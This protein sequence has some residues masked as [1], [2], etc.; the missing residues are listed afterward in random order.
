MLLMAYG[1]RAHCFRQALSPL[2]ATHFRDD[3]HGCCKVLLSFQ[4][5]WNLLPWLNFQQLIP[6]QRHSKE[7][8]QLWIVGGVGSGGGERGKMFPSYPQIL[9]T[10][11]LIA[12]A[13]CRRNAHHSVGRLQ[14]V[15]ASVWPSYY[16]YE[17]F[18]NQKL[19][20][21]TS[22]FLFLF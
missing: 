6:Q 2:Y 17:S 19:H 13:L 21:P 1:I 16:I 7:I 8:A 10:V 4:V 12:W 11:N 22:D 3:H 5:I 14:L 20:G 15:V 18:Q 9:L